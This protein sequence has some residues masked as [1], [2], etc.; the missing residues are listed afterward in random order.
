MKTTVLIFCIIVFGPLLF[1]LAGSVLLWV[2]QLPI[3]A[4]GLIWALLKPTKTHAD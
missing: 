2:V 3:F 4:V 1:V